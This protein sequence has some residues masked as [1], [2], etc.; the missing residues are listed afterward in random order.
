[1]PSFEAEL[2]EVIP[3]TSD[4]SSFRFSDPLEISYK[5]GQYLFIT[6]KG[7]EKLLIHYFSIS[8]NPTE[9]G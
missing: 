3:R 4:V 6:L 7:G 1:M 9:K 5:A 8:N 2:L